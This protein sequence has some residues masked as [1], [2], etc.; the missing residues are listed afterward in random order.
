MNSINIFTFS[1]YTFIGFYMLQSQEQLGI[2]KNHS[3]VTTFLTISLLLKK[4][5]EQFVENQA[6]CR[7]LFTILPKCFSKPPRAEM[8]HFSVILTIKCH[9]SS[10]TVSP[11]SPYMPR[12]LPNP[13]LTQNREESGP[14]FNTACLFYHFLNLRKTI[15]YICSNVNKIQVHYVSD[16]IC[17]SSN[18]AFTPP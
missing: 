13:N 17:M 12:L 2:Q 5:C 10:S 14:A 8:Y 15:K 3:V 18:K 11:S 1:Y 16:R 7:N 9:V 4:G 6:T